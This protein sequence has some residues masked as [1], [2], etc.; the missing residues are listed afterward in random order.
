[1]YI[2]TIATGGFLVNTYIV[3]LEPSGDCIII[4]PG[5]DYVSIHAVLEQYNLTPTAILLTHGHFDHITSLNDLVRHTSI[6]V[7]IHEKDGD[8]LTDARLNL[9]TFFGFPAVK[10]KAAAHLVQDNDQL[11]VAGLDIQV[12]H[13][14]GHSMG[15]VVYRIGDTAFTGDTLFQGSIGRTDFQG[16]DTQLIQRS[17]QRLVRELPADTQILSGHGG[18]STMAEERRNNIYLSSLQ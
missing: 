6:A 10:S 13:T 14:P 2:H 4:D 18:A 7:Y 11:H 15:S 12:L 16:A 17:L 1:M 5:S 3:S 9:S 8:M